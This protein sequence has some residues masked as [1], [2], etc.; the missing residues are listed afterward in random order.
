MKIPVCVFVV[1]FAA[2]VF[3]GWWGGIE[4]F[5]RTPEG[6]VWVFISLIVSTAIALAVWDVRRS[7]P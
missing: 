5:K 1:V 7:L 6:P 2:L 4:M 3:L